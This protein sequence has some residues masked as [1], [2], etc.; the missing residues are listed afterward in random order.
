MSIPPPRTLTESLFFGIVI[1]YPFFVQRVMRNEP[2]TIPGINVLKYVGSPANKTFS[3]KMFFSI[4]AI[5]VAQKPPT[6]IA[7]CWETTLA[8]GERK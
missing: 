8:P 7:K 1:E 5:V 4:P 2:I 6:L 3:P